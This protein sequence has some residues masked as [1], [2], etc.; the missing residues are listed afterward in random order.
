MKKS[1]KG[2]RKAVYSSLETLDFE[3]PSWERIHWFSI[4]VAEEVKRSKFNPDI[5]VGISR[6]GWVPAR[7]ISDL[8]EKAVLANVSVEFYEQLGE[9]KG[10]PTITQPISISVK[11]KKLLLVD[12]VAD[13]GQ[14]L[15]LVKKYLKDVG[16]LEIKIASVY[17][18]PW[19]TVIPDYYRK[20]TNLWIIFPWEIKES[21]RK[22][23]EKFRG[24][25]ITEDDIKQKLLQLGLDSKLIEKLN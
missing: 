22:I 1:K 20:E 7:I 24:Q 12:D 25:N 2:E 18:K 16:A 23:F 19:S 10:K 17:Y 9:T 21:L 5:I 13:T 15:A 6:G 8:F 11:E 14:S 3:I 4:E